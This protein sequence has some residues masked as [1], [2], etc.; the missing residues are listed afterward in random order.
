MDDVLVT[1]DPLSSADL[2][3]VDTAATCPARARGRCLD[4]LRRHACE[5][6]SRRVLIREE[7]LVSLS[8]NA[9][10]SDKRTGADWLM[11]AWIVRDSRR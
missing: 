1:S 2:D 11:T 5:L 8:P 7:S 6:G 4:I 3:V 10:R 9:G